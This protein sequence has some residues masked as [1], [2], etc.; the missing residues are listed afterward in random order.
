VRPIDRYLAELDGA[1]RGPQVAA[2][3]DFDGTIIAGYSATAL[4]QEKFKRREMSVE[5]IIE[6]ANVMSQYSLGGMSFSGLMTAAAKFMKGVTEESFRQFGEELYEKHIARKVYPETRAII[7]AHLALGHTVAIISSAT[8]YQIA[9]TA[10]DL[11][12]DHVLCSQYEVKDGVF[13]G[14]IVRPLCF[15]EGKVLAAEKLAAETG[16]DLDASYFYSD[17]SDDIELLERVGQ[18]RVLNPN[19]K[20]RAIAKERGWPVEDF[21]S[22]GS[23]S[24]LDYART[25]SATSSLVGAFWAGLPIWALT[26]SKREAANFS[27]AL[28]GDFAA[29][30]IGLELDVFG[31]K[32]LWAARPCVFIFNHQSKADVVIMAKLVR[33]DMGGV[34]KQEIRKIPVLGQLMEWAGTVFVDRA[35]TQ[36]AIKAMEPLVEA[37]RKDGRSIVIAPEGTRTLSPKLG[38]F[39]KGAFHLAMQAGVPVVPVV[40]HNA[41]DVAPKN[42]FVMRP[43]RVR[44]DVLPPVDT[45]G[46]Q[47]ANLADHV[48]EVRGMFL[49][50]LGQEDEPAPAKP[51]RKPRAAA[52]KRG[53]KA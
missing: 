42:E 43:A 47:V 15:G 32:N 3:F 51:A 36:N 28:F 46:W 7:Q 22:R 39:K 20:L 19:S 48:A 30:M 35:N 4:L 1:P 8:I 38:P 9:P 53:A 44:V 25:I 18:P 17:S 6:T 27:T 21:T 29:A 34:G 49:K 12:I 10:R 14:N 40:I 52:A 26:G 16:A 37:I 31:E 41:G 2:L 33:K 24:A 11:G 50:V 23:A 5:E 45:A 13:T